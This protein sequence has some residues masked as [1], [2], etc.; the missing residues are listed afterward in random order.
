[1][2]SKKYTPTQRITSF[3]KKVDKSGGDNACWIWK[4]YRNRDGYGRMAWFNG[5]ESA[6]RVAWILS[7]GEIPRGLSVLHNCPNG[8]NPSCCNPSHLF[9]GTQQEN[10]QDMIAKGRDVHVS[11]ER[12]GRRLH[13]GNYPRGSAIPASK[14]T[15]DQVSEIKT[16]FNAGGVTR[17][18]LAKQYGVS[19]VVIGKIIKGEIWTHV[20]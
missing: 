6:H 19:D 11:G 7:H 13:P 3:W 18:R 2:S 17:K 10:I 20:V 9:L 1:M 12:S 16:I 5:N 8:D 14:L 4:G 15:E